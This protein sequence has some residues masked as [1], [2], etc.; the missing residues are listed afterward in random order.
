MK[1][2][3]SSFILI[4]VLAS[5]FTLMT[6]AVGVAFRGWSAAECCAGWRTFDSGGGQPWIWAR[7]T[8]TLVDLSEAGGTISA[9]T[10]TRDCTLV[11]TGETDAPPTP[12][13]PE[14]SR[15]SDNATGGSARPEASATAALMDALHATIRKLIDF[16]HGLAE[17]RTAIELARAMAD[18]AEAQSANAA[19]GVAARAN[20]YAVRPRAEGTT[21]GRRITES[22]LIQTG[23]AGAL[24]SRASIRDET[25]AELAAF[26]AGPMVATVQLIGVDVDAQQC[27]PITVGEWELWI[28]TEGELE[29][30]MSV[31]S[32]A[33]FQP[34]P[35]WLPS[36]LKGAVFLRRK[37]GQRPVTGMFLKMPSAHPFTNVWRP[38]TVLTLAQPDVIRMW[39]EHQSEPGRRLQALFDDIVYEPKSF[40]P[41]EDGEDEVIEGPMTSSVGLNPGNADDF[42]DRVARINA[43]LPP[44]LNESSKSVPK[45]Y[46][47]I[48]RAAQ[49]L[50]A[51]GLYA[52]GSA[53]PYDP[54][55]ATNALLDY[56]IALEAL[57][58]GGE[59]GDLTR[60]LSQRAAVLTAGSDEERL[61]VAQTIREL[62]KAR[63]KVTH[64]VA[65]PTSEELEDLRTIVR[66]VL[67]ARLVH[68]DLGTSSL[69][70]LCDDAL[71]SDTARAE[72]IDPLRPYLENVGPLEQPGP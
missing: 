66:R 58:G 22:S 61:R 13:N 60:K 1:R 46:A 27:G 2:S 10:E 67:L 52:F 43:I 28:S 24:I 18:S 59:Q 68:D 56:V 32:L 50:L 49:R 35:G 4:G 39:S 21:A 64:G 69:E 72:L 26:L 23:V 36:L 38:L 11:P 42:A 45:R 9:V 20:D 31:P 37:V 6:G 12:A 55:H 41:Y 16:G 70:Q 47:R 57:L 3:V 25:I 33:R 54:I 17:G 63:S 34:Q 53:T 30:M 29:E 19:A 51:A 48:E 15:E 5:S 62:Y 44:E 8:V 40:I 71:L 14:T 65:G 7:P